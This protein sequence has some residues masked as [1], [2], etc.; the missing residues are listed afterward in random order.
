[1]PHGCR[2][3]PLLPGRELEDVVHQQFAVVLIVAL[4]R[5]RCRARKYPMVVLPLEE[6]GGHR[7]TRA[8]GLR[9]KNP[10]FDPIRLQTLL[11]EQEVGRGGD[12]VVL[13]IAGGVTL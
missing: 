6:P 12:L 9:I 8:D 4:E 13:R 5:R 10:A 3:A 1:M 2:N 11:C 7:G